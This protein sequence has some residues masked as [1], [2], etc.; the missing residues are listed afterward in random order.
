MVNGK[1]G[2]TPGSSAFRNGEYTLEQFVITEWEDS[3][4]FGKKRRLTNRKIKMDSC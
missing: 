1:F 2:I 3:K 4:V